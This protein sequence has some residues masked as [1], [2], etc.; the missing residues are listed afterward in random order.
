MVDFV[1]L[2]GV[3][4][5][6][7]GNSALF[8]GGGLILLCFELFTA[9]FQHESWKCIDLKLFDQYSLDWE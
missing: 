8:T 2:T 5:A 9:V 4:V 6:P 3:V 1:E 7:G